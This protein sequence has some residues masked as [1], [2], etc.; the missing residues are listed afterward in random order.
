MK[1]IIF[2]T[3]FAA[4]LVTSPAL[5]QQTQH[6]HGAATNKAGQQ[7]PGS[8]MMISSETMQDHRQKMQEMRTLMQQARAT[9]DP[10]ERQRL[11]TEHRQKMQEQMASMMQGDNA[12]MM[13]ACQEHMA[14]MH[15]MMGQMGAREE[16][17][18]SN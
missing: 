6:Q 7:T 18:P 15:D 9:T 11:M 4:G 16:M 2:A 13:T 17:S 12:A 10:A 1:R 8:G 5:A 14:M 3:V